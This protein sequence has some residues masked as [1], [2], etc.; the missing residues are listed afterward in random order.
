[1]YIRNASNGTMASSNMNIYSMLG[2][3][4][5]LKKEENQPKN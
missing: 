3:V 2:H 4:P 5:V 1:M